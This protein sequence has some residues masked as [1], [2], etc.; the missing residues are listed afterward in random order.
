MIPKKNHYSLAVLNDVATV[1]KHLDNDPFEYQAS[2][3]LINKVTSA[4]RKTI[5][6]AFKELYGDGIKTYHVKQRLEKS[7]IFLEEGMTIK[8][9]AI[10]CLYKSQSAYCTAFKKKFGMTPTEWLKIVSNEKSNNLSN[11]NA[12]PGNDDQ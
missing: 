10:A 9:A 2:G 11:R 7:K 5:E 8:L 1:K 4:N 6:K 3:D 12:Q